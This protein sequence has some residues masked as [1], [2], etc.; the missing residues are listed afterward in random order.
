MVTSI[1]LSLPTL[2]IGYAG[3]GSLVSPDLIRS[4]FSSALRLYQQIY[5][6]SG[7]LLQLGDGHA[8]LEIDGQGTGEWRS[9]AMFP[10]APVL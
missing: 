7:W 1:L 9:P 3:P 8:H 4:E 10:S 2:P 6:P 5:E